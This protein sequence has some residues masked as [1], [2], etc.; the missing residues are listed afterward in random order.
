MWVG[1]CGYACAC[2]CVC[3]RVHVCV[4]CFLFDNWTDEDFHSAAI[5][6]LCLSYYVN[7]LQNERSFRA[8]WYSLLGSC[9]VIVGPNRRVSPR[10]S[11]VKIS[12][13]SS[14]RADLGIIRTPLLRLAHRSTHSPLKMV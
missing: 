11:I 10:T 12:T 9:F 5:I 14:K 8:P 1:G 13:G 3:A 4:P 6:V 2:A 7:V